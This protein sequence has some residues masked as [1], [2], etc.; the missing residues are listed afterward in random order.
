MFFPPHC[1]FSH[2]RTVFVSS[3]SFLLRVRASPLFNK[4]YLTWLDST[5]LAPSALSSL[6]RRCCCYAVVTR[7]ITAVSVQRT[8][9]ATAYQSTL[10]T[11]VTFL[12]FCSPSFVHA[13]AEPLAWRLKTSLG[14]TSATSTLLDFTGMYVACYHEETRELRGKRDNMQET[15]P[16]ASRRGRSRPGWT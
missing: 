2:R 5:T 15:M 13:E 6:C 8:H 11:H 7:K 1:V 16:G 4:R 9:D 14:Y 3:L 10:F 12:F